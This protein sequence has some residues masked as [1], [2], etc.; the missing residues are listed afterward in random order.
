MCE[1]VR[2]SF[3]TR[4]SATYLADG[5]FELQVALHE[6][7]ARVGRRA[8]FHRC[9]QIKHGTVLLHQLV[10]RLVVGV[11]RRADHAACERVK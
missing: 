2:V 3:S 9:A 7:V 4:R 6:E 11:L 8:A 10:Q 1:S 5:I